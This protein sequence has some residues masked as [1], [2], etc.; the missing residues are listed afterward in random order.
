MPLWE[1]FLV[2]RVVEND[3]AATVHFCRRGG[4]PHIRRMRGAIVA[5]PPVPRHSLPEWVSGQGFF[6]T[7]AERGPLSATEQLSFSY[8]PYCRIAGILDVRDRSRRGLVR[9]GFLQDDAGA[10]PPSSTL[11]ARCGGIKR[12]QE[13]RT[14]MP[15][16]LDRQTND[17][18]GR[19][20][21]V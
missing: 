13:P 7:E 17:A 21:I 6:N 12:L 3:G 20:L 16:H 8:R 15:M 5:S 1:G 18:F 2:P 4:R 11:P 19:F 9:P 14:T 10:L